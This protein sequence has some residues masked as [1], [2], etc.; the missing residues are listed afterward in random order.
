MPKFREMIG[1]IGRGFGEQWTAQEEEKRAKEAKRKEKEEETKFE[2]KKIILTEMAKRG[3]IGLDLD[4]G[5]LIKTPKA[6]MPSNL[7]ASLYDISGQPTGY[8]ALNPA[9][10]LKSII[11]GTRPPEDIRKVKSEQEIMD[12]LPLIAGEHAG[13]GKV[14]A[15]QGTREEGGFRF[16]PQG[17]MIGEYSPGAEM[18]R[19]GLEML[20]EILKKK[21]TSY[22]YER[23]LSEAVS[24]VSEGEDIDKEFNKLIKLYPLKVTEIK[25][26]LQ[27]AMPQ[28]SMLEGAKAQVQ[29]AVNSIKTKEDLELFKDFEEVFKKEGINTKAVIKAAERKLKGRR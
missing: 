19:G 10:V 26:S 14:L 21:D 23:K 16:S 8:K 28:V 9:D 3:E 11:S 18:Q 1:D 17:E 7:E 13:G 25:N 22:D 6:A 29:G 15:P 12:M 2:I 24:R 5:N 27:S 20:P 4:S